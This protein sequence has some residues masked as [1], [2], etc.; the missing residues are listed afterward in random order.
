MKIFKPILISLVVVIMLAIVVQAATTTNTPVFNAFTSI[1]V[2]NKTAWTKVELL[3]PGTITNFQVKCTTG[4]VYLKPSI[5]LAG[6]NVGG[7]ESGTNTAITL[8]ADKMVKLKNYSAQNCF[9]VKETNSLNNALTV[10]YNRD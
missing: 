5:T 1:A 3:Y 6:V 9:W 4:H 10:Y 8:P 7:T 2:S